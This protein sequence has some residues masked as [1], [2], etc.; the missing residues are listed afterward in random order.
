MPGH[1]RFDFV[2][3]LRGM[4]GCDLHHLMVDFTRRTFYNVPEPSMRAV[5]RIHTGKK[6]GFTLIELLVVI[7]I[8][9]I[10]AAMLLPALARAKQKGQRDSCISNLRQIGV[11]FE[12]YLNDNENRFPDRRD[13]KTTLPGGYLPWAASWPTSDPRGGWA[14][15]VLKD[16]G[17]SSSLWSCPASL[18][19]AAGNAAQSLQITDT[20]PEA[21]QV[22]YWL[23]R[24]DRPDDPVPL[25]DFWGKTENQVVSDLQANNTPTIDPT[26]GVINGASDVELAVDPYFP[27]TI[28]S[29]PAALKGHTIH[30]GGRCRVFLDGHVQYIKDA[31]TPL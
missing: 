9:S 14:A 15:I 10:L 13:L 21:V 7:A 19:S 26:I 31:R 11:S 30:P 4:T 8:I 16:S 24:F 28:P 17:A 25:T 6:T 2:P 1:Q 12:L 3:P 29:V 18:N 23:W 22:R 27:A 20:T 5:E